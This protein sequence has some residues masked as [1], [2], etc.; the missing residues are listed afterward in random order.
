ML[1]LSKTSRA[2][3]SLASSAAM[4][5]LSRYSRSR[6]KS[7]RCSKSTFIRPGAGVRGRAG[8]GGMGATM[9]GLPLADRTCVQP[10][11]THVQCDCQAARAHDGATGRGP[12]R[13]PGIAPG[14]A[15]PAGGVDGVRP[16]CPT[17]PPAAAGPGAA[18]FVR[19]RACPA[20]PVLAQPDLADRARAVRPFGRHAVRP[21][22]RVAHLA[23]LPV[24]D[25]R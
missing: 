10:D 17:R 12:P 4:A 24:R 18:G 7:T 13:V 15:R 8:T 21:G 16:R 22:H 2:P 19:A 5:R 3:R 1:L 6:A 9:K 14:L 23:G 11:L 20:H 25:P